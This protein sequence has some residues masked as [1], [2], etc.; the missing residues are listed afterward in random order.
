[1]KIFVGHDSRQPENTEVCVK[2]IER[3]GHT[4]H[5][6]DRNELK[7]QYGYERD[8]EDG[9]SEFTYTRF[10]VPYLCNYEGEAMFCDSDF[11]WR[12]DPSR[13]MTY[14]K[15]SPP[16]VS[17]VKHLVKQV[18]EDHKFLENKNVWYPRKWWSSMMYFNNAHPDSKKLTV[19][20]VNTQSA[21]WLH[22]F[23][24][25]DDIGSL[26]ETFNYLV[27]YYCFLDNPTAVHFTDGTPLYPEYANDEFAG[28]YNALKRL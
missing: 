12:N 20:A 19:E 1:M 6:L 2:S 17:C 27:G 7:E 13:I 21:Q 18:R 16:A 22:R 11:V 24:W 8:S 14:V 23:E 28:D 10:L 5:L 9:S 25:T 26:P 3:F 15:A 4:V